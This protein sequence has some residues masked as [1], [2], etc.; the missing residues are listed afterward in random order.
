MTFPPSHPLADYAGDL[1]THADHLR[2]YADV[3]ENSDPE[4]VHGAMLVYY[5]QDACDTLPTVSE[6][7]DA[8]LASLWMLGSHIH[9]VSTSERDAT[10][11]EVAS[12][13]IEYVRM[14]GVAGDE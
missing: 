4:E 11:E 5:N 13:A 10:M 14:H 8:R 9:H 7:V 2:A 6:D 3:L 1:E 12:D